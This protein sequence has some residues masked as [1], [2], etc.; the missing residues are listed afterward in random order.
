M[1]LNRKKRL[2][3]LVVII[4]VLLLAVGARRLFLRANF[5]AASSAQ[6]LSVKIDGQTLQAEVA[7]TPAAQYRGLSNRPALCATCAM[8][9][10]FPNEGLQQ[11]VM[12]QMEFPLDIIFIN[13]HR[14]IKIAPDLP[15]D[16]PGP[17]VIYDSGGPAD[18][19]LEVN[20]GYAA[21]QGIKLGDYVEY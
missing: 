9:F 7:A 15:P 12:R 17:E 10:L 18:T 21:K 13:E 2:W 1:A 19:V 16:G 14:I 6:T 4:I 20:A 5:F 8:I 3:I 11:F